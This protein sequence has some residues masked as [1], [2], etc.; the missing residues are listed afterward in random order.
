MKTIKVSNIEIIIGNDK[1]KMTPDELMKLKE[2][3]DDVFPTKEI[4]YIPY[5]VQE[6]R[7]YWPAYP[8]VPYV[9]KISDSTFTSEKYHHHMNTAWQSF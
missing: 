1:I 9:Y 2:E 4:K 6:P 7:P 5:P 8:V 3:L